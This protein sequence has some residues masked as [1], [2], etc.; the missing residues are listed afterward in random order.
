M[1]RPVERQPPD[2]A[3]LTADQLSDETTGAFALA[4][5]S[6]VIETIAQRAAALVSERDRG[7]LDID[8]A[9]ASWVV[10]VANGST[11]SSNATRSRTTAPAAASSSTAK[12]C[13]TGSKARNESP[14]SSCAGAAA[15]LRFDQTCKCPGAAEAARGRTRRD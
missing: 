1:T 10:A 13:A 5:P 12:N 2:N 6:E 7:F 9:C 14:T 4:V 15:V 11:T 8:G 3:Q